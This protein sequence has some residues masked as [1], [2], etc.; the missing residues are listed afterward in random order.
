MSRV[1]GIY[2]LD[3]RSFL[4]QDDIHESRLQKFFRLDGVCHPALPR[5]TYRPNIIK[6]FPI[7]LQ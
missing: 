4:R 3:D 1:G 7:F 6:T 2:M 5:R